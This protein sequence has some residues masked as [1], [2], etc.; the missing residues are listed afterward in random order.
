MMTQLG[1]R[2]TTFKLAAVAALAVCT[3]QTSSLA[4][5]QQSVSTYAGTLIQPARGDAESDGDILRRFEAQLIE[6]ETGAFFVMADD[7]RSGCPWPDSFGRC[8]KTAPADS[9][10]PHLVYNYDG[11]T[12][13]IALPPLMVALPDEIAVDTEWEQSGWLYRAIANKQVDGQPTW[14]LE[15]SERRGRRQSLTVDAAT[16]IMLTAEADVF[17]GQGDQF[18]LAVARSTVEPLSTEVAAAM[19]SLQSELLS[20]QSSLKRRPDGFQRELS[21]R[22]IADAA[23]KIDQLKTLAAP[24]SLT[25]FIAIIADD[26]QAQQ[27]RLATVADRAKALIGSPAP[28]FVLAL[29]SGG[30]LTGEALSGKTVVLHFWDYR[31]AP[32]SEPYGQTGYLEFLFNQKRASN[33]QIVGVSTNPELQSVENRGRGLRSIRKLTE[34]MNISYPIGYDDGSLLKSLGDPREARGQL[35]LWVVLSPDG[36]ISHYHAGYYEVDAARGLE[37]LETALA[38]IAATTK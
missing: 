12:Y 8:G 38:A 21:Q 9:V 3:L 36:T 16:G 14:T 28:E 4:Q 24:T 11:T 26:L 6:S 30:S 17:M 5:Q 15:A 10:Q 33:F 34:F 35:P 27:T 37:E 13:V 20:I 22:Q 25:S 7:P 23:A 32:L 29:S 1:H 31:D 19:A 2:L 18:R